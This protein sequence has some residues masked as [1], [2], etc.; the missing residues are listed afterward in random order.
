MQSLF[1]HEPHPPAVSSFFDSFTDWLSDMFSFPRAFSLPFAIAC[2]GRYS[3][4]ICSTTPSS[5]LS[6][7]ANSLLF[8]P[9]ADSPVGATGDE[10]AALTKRKLPADSDDCCCIC[11]DAMKKNQTVSWFRYS[12]TITFILKSLDCCRFVISS[13][14]TSFTRVASIN[15]WRRISRVPSANMK[16]NTPP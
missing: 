10:I 16:S 12:P 4:H 7:I 14:F 8:R 3:N 1:G 9:P 5:C 6:S 2:K 15:G 11:L 13:V